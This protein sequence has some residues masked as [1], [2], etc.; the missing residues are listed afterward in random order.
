[1]IIQKVI[2]IL[3]LICVFIYIYKQLNILNKK[4]NFINLEIKKIYNL[5][6]NNNPILT[7]NNNFINE[8]FVNDTIISTV[9]NE[10][11]IPNLTNNNIFAN[12]L[13]DI[14]INSISN[15]T[16]LLEKNNEIFINN[17]FDE[18]VEI[19]SNDDNKIISYQNSIILEN[20]DLIENNK[21]IIYTDSDK[22]NNSIK[23]QKIEIHS[24]NSNS[25]IKN[26]K[27]NNSIKSQ[28]IEIHSDNSN[29]SIK[30]RKSNNSIKSQKIEIYNN[31]LNNSFNSQKIEIH[32]DNSN[33]S[34]ESKK[35][36]NSIENK[37]N[38][39]IKFNFDKNK[40]FKLK[41][42]DIKTI[43]INNNI[44]LLKDN[45]NKNKTKDELINEIC[46][47]K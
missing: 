2:F 28:K 5:Y 12:L 15:F 44:L 11:I 38:N 6:N 25:S 42:I 14:S 8:N 43:A 22:S 17:N 9:V 1:M 47:L 3:L 7:H 40:L 29:S 41:L 36:N 39:N 32:S 20:K 13:N 21:I 46:K 18:H 26:R 4:I 31:N 37:E 19:Y 30:S 27:S 24:D 23:S 45:S 33:S 35:S 16:N 10:N 34:I